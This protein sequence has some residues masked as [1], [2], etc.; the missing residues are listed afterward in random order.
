MKRISLYFIGI[1]GVCVFIV[2]L[3]VY[4][5]FIRTTGTA[6]ATFPATRGTI[7]EIVKARGSVIAQS[8]FQLGF[9]FNANV[10]K[11]YVAEG[12][13]VTAGTL[14]MRVDDSAYQAQA[15]TATA[16]IAQMQA[17]LAKLLAGATPADIA[18]SEAA[19]D[20]AR[21]GMVDGIQSA[22]TA[23]DDAIHAQVDRVI[24][25]G[26]SSNPYVD[27]RLVPVDSALW[28]EIEQKRVT[29]ESL[30][31]AWNASVSA[32]TPDGNLDAAISQ[33]RNAT[34]QVGFFLDRVAFMLNGVL[35]TPDVPQTTLDAFTAAIS[36]ARTSVSA[37]ATALSTAEGTLRTAQQALALKTAPP[38]PEDIAAAKAQIA[39]VQGELAAARSN[40]A[41]AV[42]K[43]PADGTVV[44]FLVHEGELYAAGQPAVAFYSPNLKVIAD[45]SELDIGKIPASASSPVKLSLDAFPGRTYG[46]HLVSVD[47]Q[48]ID[49]EG[50]KYYRIN[51]QFDQ[52]PPE[53][54]PGMSADLDIILQ[55]K[56]GVITIPEFLTYNRENQAFVRVMVN[57]T[58]V[59]RAVTLG[60]SDGDRVEVISGVSE[61]DIIAAAAQ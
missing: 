14:L 8:D 56:D 45:L 30:L 55:T 37:S 24:I 13:R 12:S 40:I 10:T 52:M 33:A 21:Q 57:G 58:P 27:P 23:C 59:E 4:L 36:T 17:N 5:R 16:K 51:V 20:D 46:G 41:N 15:T 22:F 1:G 3:W 28:Q 50:D 9:P 48:E 42:I 29:M 26:R 38:R 43:A 2:G 18:V 61:N 39:Q 11:L 19:V 44:K 31:N 49:K 60:I 7:S 6:V 35:A 25:G 47:P 53:V 32:L 34:S 54:R